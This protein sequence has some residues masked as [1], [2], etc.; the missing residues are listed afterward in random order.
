[1]LI[2]LMI[3]NSLFSQHTIIENNGEFEYKVNNQS[4]IGHDST[5][6]YFL[7][8]KGGED[9]LFHSL[10]IIFAGKNSIT[11][12]IFNSFSQKD[13]KYSFKVGTIN[14][15]ISE[16][17][18]I[19][20]SKYIDKQ[21]GESFISD[22]YYPLFLY[23][24]NL[25]G[26]YID[27]NNTRKNNNFISAFTQSDNDLFSISSDEISHNINNVKVEYNQ[28]ILNFK[29]RPFIIVENKIINRSGFDLTDCYFST[30]LDPDLSQIDLEFL[31]MRNDYGV[32]IDDKIIF[33]SPNTLT[34]NFYVGFK[35]LQKN[36]IENG[37]YIIRK[38]RQLQNVN[39]NILHP[40]VLLV[41]NDI[42]SALQSK[43]EKMEDTDVRAIAGVGPIN[44]SSNDTIVFTY[45]IGIAESVEDYL[46]DNLSNMDKIINL[47]DVVEDFYYNNLFDF[48]LS[49]RIS[50]ITDNSKILFCL[51]D[52]QYYAH[53]DLTKLNKGR[54]L[55]LI[56]NNGKF[57][58]IEKIILE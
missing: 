23:A 51:D 26:V 3:L 15:E 35:Y 9:N 16:K 54:Y 55:V 58:L 50:E 31:N 47:L 43:N 11:G 34:K 25:P 44:I 42:Y 2:L 12:E 7:Y 52:Y 21:T 18:N 5:K 17:Y 8:P 45:T 28:R 46:D 57:E 13:G 6:G 30:Y 19:Y 36:L 32:N 27:D 48:A 40:D 10:G 56:K 53:H 41:D 20:Q 1:M 14:S 24:D 37:N 33:F 4:V 22:Y 29:E 38:N 49:V 39:Y